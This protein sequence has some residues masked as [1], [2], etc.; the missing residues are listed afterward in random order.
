MHTV[1]INLTTFSS[2]RMPL[3]SHL[4]HSCLAQSRSPTRSS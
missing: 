3:L 1:F 4:K 2:K